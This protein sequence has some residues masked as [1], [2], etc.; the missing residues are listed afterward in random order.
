M[1]WLDRFKSFLRRD[2][3]PEH[4][5]RGALG[6]NAARKHLEKAGLKFLVANYRTTR[7]EIDLV[8]DR[9]STRLNSSHSQQSRM[10]SSA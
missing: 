4:L 6:E 8:L 10:P 7:G 2:A 9:K 1:G 5:R 3:K